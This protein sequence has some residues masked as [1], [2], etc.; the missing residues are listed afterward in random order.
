M[1]AGW[2]LAWRSKAGRTG[3]TSHCSITALL[4]HRANPEHPAPWRVDGGLGIV[5]SRSRLGDWK[6][7]KGETSRARYRLVV[8]VGGLNRELI[9]KQWKGW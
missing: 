8:Y 9:E 6:I 3:R 1:R 2:T 7:A 5:P 4:D